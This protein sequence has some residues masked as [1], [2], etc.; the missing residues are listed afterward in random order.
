[1]KPSISHF[2][3]NSN[4]EYLKPNVKYRENINI[5]EKENKIYGQKY[6]NYF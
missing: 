5:L 1:L 4:I 3:L 6:I 2:G